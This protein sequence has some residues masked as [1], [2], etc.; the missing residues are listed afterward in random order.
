MNLAQQE[1][2]ALFEKLNALKDENSRVNAELVKAKRDAGLK[3]EQ[4]K[5]HIVSLQDDLKRIRQQ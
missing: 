4:D 3:Q 1:K 5:N 2:N